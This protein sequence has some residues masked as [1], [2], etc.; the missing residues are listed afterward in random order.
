[1]FVN[2]SAVF[3]EN[4]HDFVWVVGAKNA[5]RKRAVEVATTTDALA[6]VESGLEAERG[7]FSIR[8]RPSG[9]T[10]PSGSPTN[11]RGHNT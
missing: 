10:K 9:K 8:S 1:M 6:R 4:G 5:I 7:S 3:A 2:K 11:G